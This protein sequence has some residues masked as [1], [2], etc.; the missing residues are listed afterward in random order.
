ME[1]EVFCKFYKIGTDE[2]DSFMWYGIYCKGCADGVIS[3]MKDK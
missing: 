3:M 1:F 2:K